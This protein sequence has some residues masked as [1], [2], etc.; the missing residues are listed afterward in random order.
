M[1]KHIT[2]G[3]KKG[4]SLLLIPRDATRRLIIRRE[5]KR[6]KEKGTHIQREH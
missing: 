3:I 4:I 1:K 2:L 5:R 6:E